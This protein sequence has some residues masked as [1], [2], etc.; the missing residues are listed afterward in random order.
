MFTYLKATAGSQPHRRTAP[1]GITKAVTAT[2]ILIK[3]AW[4]VFSMNS[5]AG[6]G[7]LCEVLEV[8][9]NSYAKGSRSMGRGIK[10]WFSYRGLLSLEI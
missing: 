5:S 6:D 2:T 8:A 3:S 10:N 7:N 4:N 1:T 9:R